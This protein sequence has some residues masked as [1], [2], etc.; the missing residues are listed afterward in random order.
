MVLIKWMF[1]KFEVKAV[2]EDI[3]KDNIPS[4]WVLQKIRNVPT[5]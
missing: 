2:I 1:L 5:M 4:Q 3:L